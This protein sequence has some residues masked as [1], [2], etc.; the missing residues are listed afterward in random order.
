MMAGSVSRTLSSRSTAR[1]A[2]VPAHRAAHSLSLKRREYSTTSRNWSVLSRA[3][4]GRGRL[5]T[6]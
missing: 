4:S 6:S 2:P 3:M 1:P 5:V